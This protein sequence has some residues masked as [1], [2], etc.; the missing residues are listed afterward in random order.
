MC[1]RL[2][3]PCPLPHSPPT[4][5]FEAI[6]YLRFLGNIGNSLRASLL[7]ELYS[8]ESLTPGKCCAFCQ[9]VASPPPLL[10]ASLPSP[11]HL[12]VVAGSPCAFLAVPEWGAAREIEG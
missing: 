2:H 7:E 8:I 9:S 12:G 5:Q 11:L 10:L 3:C 6:A 4:I 1:L